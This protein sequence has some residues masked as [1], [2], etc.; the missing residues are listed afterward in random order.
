M[1]RDEPRTSFEDSLEKSIV[2]AGNCVGSG[3]CGRS[4]HIAI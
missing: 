4:I 2:L 3:A 1:R